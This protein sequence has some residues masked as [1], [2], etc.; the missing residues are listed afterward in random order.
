MQPT[1]ELISI[2]VIQPSPYQ[3]RKDF[4]PSKL[5]ELAKSIDRDGL[6]EPIVVRPVN[7]HYELIAGERRWR[8]AGLI[9][10]N[11]ILSRVVQATDLQARRMCAAE[12]LQR[13]DLGAVE[14]VHAITELIDAEM[15]EDDTY[16]LSAESPIERVKWLL[17]KLFND[18]TN[19]TDHFTNK[20]ISKVEQIFDS[21]PRPI[22]WYSFYANDFR[23]IVNLEED[24]AEMAI[25]NKLNKSQTKE[26][27]KLKKDA[28]DIF[29][30][31]A[32]KANDEGKIVIAPDPWETDGE[33]RD[34]SDI[35]AEG[36]RHFKYKAG[37]APTLWRH[38]EP[39][40]VELGTYDGDEWYT[41]KEFIEAA[42]ALMGEIDLDPASCA[43]AERVVQAVDWYTKDDDGL[44]QGWYG[45]VWCNPPYSYPLIE[46][47]TQKAIAEKD[48]GNVKD[49][50]LLVNNCT[51]AAWFVALAER[52]PVMFTKGRARFWQEDQRTFA[53]RQ[54]QAIFYLG[55][56]I[57]RFHSC[58]AH[59]AY[60]P[61][62]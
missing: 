9:G 4:S 1:L 12:N 17:G 60:A 44:A 14:I 15:I 16:S 2:G 6:I 56:N 32:G 28:P 25:K 34:L 61:I 11:E 30:S 3:H 10:H 5:S 42:R 49:G 37:S 47:F 38:E 35:G 19:E 24:V 53:T 23:T 13:Q 50:L 8:A 43:I 57:E 48:A 54:G 46:K 33:A 22:E 31:L 41:P 39:R 45:R 26:L 27:A 55:P 59:L 36:I 7:E 20:F 29:Q 52:Y 21:L 18:K 51:D 62:G 58:F 40:E